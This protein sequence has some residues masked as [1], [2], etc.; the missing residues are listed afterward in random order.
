MKDGKILI[1]GAGLG[2]L[3]AAACLLKQGFDVEIYEQAPQLGEVGAGI[4]ISANAARVMRHI[5]A[6]ERIV[7]TGVTPEEYRFRTYQEGDVLQTIPLGTGYV[8]KHGVPYVTIHRADLHAILVD[9]VR[10]LKPDCIHVASAVTGFAED[11]SG[12][13]LEITGKGKVR[14][15]ALIG[16][17]GIKSAIRPA[18]VGPTE[19]IYTGDVV[20]RVTVPMDSMPAEMRTERTEIWVGPGRHAVT[21]ALRHGRLLNFVGCVE[22]DKLE[23]ES[24]V[25]PRPWAEMR[26]DFDGWHPFITTIIEKAPRDECYRWAMKIRKPLTNWSSAR[27]TLLGDAAHPTLPYMA[28]GAAMA[29]E[30]GA[31]IARAFQQEGDVSA[32]IRLYQRNRIERTTRVVNESSANRDLFHKPRLQD[33]RDSFAKR[34]MNAERTAWLFSYDPLTVPLV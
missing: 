31:V 26:A 34:D 15:D 2:G 27:A 8:A 1:A 17:D 22:Y 13:T 16:C 14:G 19:A 20:W 29:M 6:L 4:Q 25:T 11:A 12:V 28:Q 21:Y 7:Q 3:T 24:W 9:V 33:I 10:G 32:A 30:D 5:G 18:I 23:E